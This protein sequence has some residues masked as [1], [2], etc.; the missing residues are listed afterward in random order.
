MTN[1][2][3]GPPPRNGFKR[4]KVLPYTELPL[5]NRCYTLNDERLWCVV[6]DMSAETAVILLHPA[7]RHP[8]KYVL[9]PPDASLVRCMGS[10]MDEA[11]ADGFSPT[12]FTT[13]DLHYAGL[14]ADDP[15]MAEFMRT[16]RD[17]K[18]S[19]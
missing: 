8:F 9:K 15:K 2:S 17:D 14:V 10:T 12:D 16:P 5:H 18:E 11:A 4:L 19:D 7:G 1:T 3:P 13:R 6:R